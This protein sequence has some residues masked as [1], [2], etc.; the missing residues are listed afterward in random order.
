MVL[1]YT[2]EYRVDG[3][4]YSMCDVS[5]DMY[6][7]HGSNATTIS[8]GSSGYNTSSPDSSTR[9]ASP[10]PD[11]TVPISASSPSSANPNNWMM[12]GSCT[13]TLRDVSL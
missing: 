1:I 7:N 8:S 12:N 3:R 13:A 6:N 11:H 10:H 4:R 2:N 9:G 5:P